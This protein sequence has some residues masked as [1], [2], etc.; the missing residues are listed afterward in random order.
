MWV[1][2]G[3][4]DSEQLLE[5]I[6]KLLTEDGIKAS[7][8]GKGK[9]VIQL[10]IVEVES[11]KKFCDRLSG[12]LRLKQE[13]LENF[14]LILGIREKH[15][16]E[17]LHTHPDWTDELV[18]YYRTIAVV[19]DNTFRSRNRQPNYYETKLFTMLEQKG[20]SA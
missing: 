20:I 2:I 6:A 4:T 8:Q 10:R 18:D 14:E 5:E 19:W 3:L 16:Q 1:S 12:K 15:Y 7:L 13:A 17:S 11:L 9:R